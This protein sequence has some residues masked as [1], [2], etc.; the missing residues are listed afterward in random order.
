M[1]SIAEPVTLDRM[2]KRKQTAKEPLPPPDSG[3]SVLYIR[4][5]PKVSQALTRMIEED[6]LEPGRQDVGMEAVLM[7]LKSKG[8][9]PPKP[10]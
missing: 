7:L 2:A 5:P 3:A 9:W 8:Y 4:L 6:P 1:A 10:E